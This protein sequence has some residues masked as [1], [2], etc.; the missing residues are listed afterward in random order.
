MSN[1]SIAGYQGVLLYGIKLF[2][3]IVSRELIA[4]CR[5]LINIKKYE[6]L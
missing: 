6:I 5:E 3:I 1:S 4:G 2:D